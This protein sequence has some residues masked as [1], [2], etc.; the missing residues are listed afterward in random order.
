MLEVCHSLSNCFFVAST[1]LLKENTKVS[2][3]L[4]LDMEDF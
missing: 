3:L 4:V 1:T 2:K